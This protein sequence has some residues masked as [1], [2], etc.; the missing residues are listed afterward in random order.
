MNIEDEITPEPVPLKEIPRTLR[1]HAP[2]PNHRARQEAFE[3]EL[4]EAKGTWAAL[5]YRCLTLSEE[6]KLC[7]ESEGQGR[8]KDIYRDFGDVVML[9][10]ESW[11]RQV[12]RY[13]FAERK[14][15]PKVHA[16]TRHRDLEDIRN[17]RDKLIL[18]VPLTIRRATVTRQ[19]NAILKA[20][21]EEREAVVPREQ[22]TAKRKLMKSKLRKDTVIKMLDLYEL[23]KAKPDL[24]L[25]QLGEDAGI[26][27][28][29]NRWKLEVIDI[30]QERIRMAISVSRSLNQARNLIWNA[31][32]GR[33]PSIAKLVD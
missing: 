4:R 27:L 28:D 10:F 14:I 23:R 3:D 2:I 32:E 9:R 31:T 20:A 6:Y 21:Y 17:L 16:Y 8:L 19:I 7:C 33:F 26:E 5:W 11:W 22:S 1:R 25:W 29:F 12:G 24:T 30:K 15:H 13:L 18:E